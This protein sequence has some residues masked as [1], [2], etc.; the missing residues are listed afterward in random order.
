MRKE[1]NPRSIQGKSGELK[2][3]PKEGAALS[4][5]DRESTKRAKSGQKEFSLVP[6][7]VM[8][9]NMEMNSL[10]EQNMELQTIDEI[11]DEHNLDIL[12]NVDGEDNQLKEA[13]IL[14]RDKLIEEYSQ[15]HDFQT[16]ELKRS[17][18]RREGREPTESE[19]RYCEM[20]ILY[21]PYD[22]VVTGLTATGKGTFCLQKIILWENDPAIAA[23]EQKIHRKVRIIYNP[24]IFALRTAYYLGKID[25]LTGEM[26]EEE[27][28][29]ASELQYNAR[30][31]A[32]GRGPAVVITELPNPTVLPQ[33]R[34]WNGK[35]LRHTEGTPL[36]GQFNKGFLTLK[37]LTEERLDPRTV[38]FTSVFSPLKRVTAYEHMENN[39]RLMVSFLVRPH[40]LAEEVKHRRQALS[41]TDQQATAVTFLEKEGVDI[42]LENISEQHGFINTLF[43]GSKKKIVQFMVA[44]VKNA[45][46]PKAA[47]EKNDF[48][49][50]EWI[51][52]LRKNG[53]MSDL[54]RSSLV[55]VD[56]EEIE[57]FI[58][59]QQEY[60]Q[61]I[62]VPRYNIKHAQIFTNQLKVHDPQ[63][64]TNYNQMTLAEHNLYLQKLPIL[65]RSL[66]EGVNRQA[67]FL[68]KK[69]KLLPKKTA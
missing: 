68:A 59:L 30:L 56:Q 4:Q 69:K 37:K 38:S 6:H 67:D 50:R 49:F 24:W 58:S 57:S 26:T 2:G 21:P 23:L 63:H 60:F 41:E 14:H 51:A 53:E 19:I 39:S 12:K 32:I 64:Q 54:A 8:S 47:V 3:I 48:I 1:Y 43:K 46:A 33:R 9:L 5:T 15:I 42:G 18:F 28:E 11:M 34:F 55:N 40:E 65:A 66:V 35:E 52:S 25:H 27:H 13:Y 7:M 62:V 44:Y 10:Q 22:E 17:I 29:I 16:Q 45:T 31:E 36:V 20:S 61:H